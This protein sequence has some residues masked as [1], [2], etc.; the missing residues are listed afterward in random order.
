VTACDEQAEAFALEVRAGVIATPAP[1]DEW[2]FDW[3]Y[4]NPPPSFERQ[5]DEALG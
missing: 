3:V 4:A 2:M 5:R 1:P